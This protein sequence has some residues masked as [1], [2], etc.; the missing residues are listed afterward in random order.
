MKSE[1]FCN[2]Y[3]SLIDDAILILGQPPCRYDIRAM[4]S[5]AREEAGLF[6]AWEY[7]ILIEE[8]RYRPY[9]HKLAEIID[10]QILS[11]GERNPK[12]QGL[13]DFGQKE[14]LEIDHQT[15]R[16]TCIPLFCLRFP[17]LIRSTY[18]LE[19]CR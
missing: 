3:R 1:A 8:E 10:L 4:G 11:L 18:R 16:F 2:F 14:G 15:F 12:H 6:S 17:L 13:F 7:F 5:L 9:L 19:S